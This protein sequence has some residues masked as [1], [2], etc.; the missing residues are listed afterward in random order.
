MVQ[1]VGRRNG[2]KWY[3]G[4]LV[5]LDILVNFMTFGHYGETISSRTG[6]GY[7]YR[8]QPWVFFRPIIDF[9]FY[10][11]LTPRQWYYPCHCQRFVNWN[12]GRTKEEIVHKIVHRRGLTEEQA[13][14]IINTREMVPDSHLQMERS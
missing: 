10:C 12:V 14:K 2:M 11:R 7:L 9:L 5:L 1:I 8:G 3:E 6:K 13:W 4:V